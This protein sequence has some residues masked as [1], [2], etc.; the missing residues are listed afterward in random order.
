[1][2]PQAS[3]LLESQKQKG[4]EKG[5]ENNPFSPRQ[6]CSFPPPAVTQTHGL[7]RESSHS[8]EVALATF[9]LGFLTPTSRGFRALAHLRVVDYFLLF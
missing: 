2:V 8:S 6:P 9:S 5:A 3:S 7:S 4:L 1:M